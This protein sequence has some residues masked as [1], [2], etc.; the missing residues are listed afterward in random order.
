MNGK[1]SVYGTGFAFGLWN[2]VLHTSR[3]EFGTVTARRYNQKF[4]T[5]NT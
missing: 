4:L 1:Q 2:G 5:D 3:L